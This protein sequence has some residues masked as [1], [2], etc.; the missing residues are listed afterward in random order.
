MVPAQ[1]LGTNPIVDTEFAYLYKNPI[2]TDPITGA[3]SNV[4][5]GVMISIF[6]TETTVVDIVPVPQVL[7]PLLATDNT[8]K[9]EITCSAVKWI[10]HDLRTGLVSPMRPAAALDPTI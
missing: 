7:T 5:H 9:I 3:T 8:K 10:N 4:L 2:T 6:P 1:T